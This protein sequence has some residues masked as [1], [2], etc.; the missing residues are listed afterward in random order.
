MPVNHSLDIEIV[1]E[2][3]TKALT[4]IEHQSGPSGA[5]D[6]PQDRGGAA[7]DFDRATHGAQCERIGHSG[8]LRVHGGGKRR[9]DA[10]SAGCQE[11]AT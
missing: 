7:V 3:D 2:V 5:V 11:T 9:H 10:G 8:S 4:G 6:E 1:R